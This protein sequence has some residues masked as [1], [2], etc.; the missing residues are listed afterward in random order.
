MGSVNLSDSD[1]R[2]PC[3]RKSVH[4]V[5]LA[6]ESERKAVAAPAAATWTEP[7]DYH[8][9]LPGP[10]QGSARFREDARVCSGGEEPPWPFCA[11][12]TSAAAISVLPE[13]C[14]EA[15]G[16]VGQAFGFLAEVAATALPTFSMFAFRERAG[17]VVYE[18]CRKRPKE[19]QESL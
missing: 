14:K 10:R 7:L 5:Q 3:K 12:S 1:S 19:K 8:Q 6:V 16:E 15:Q 13:T 11:S 9:G 18:T 2:F 17:R 4:P